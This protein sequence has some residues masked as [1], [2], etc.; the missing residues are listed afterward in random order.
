M[1]PLGMLGSVQITSIAVE[2][3]AI[4]MTSSGADIWCEGGTRVGARILKGGG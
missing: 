4:A 1:T 2:D 3:E